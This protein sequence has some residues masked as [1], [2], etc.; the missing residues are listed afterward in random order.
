MALSSLLHPSEAFTE[1]MVVMVVRAAGVLR[2]EC[3]RG[4]M[5]VGEDDES[6]DLREWT[7]GVGW[8]VGVCGYSDVASL[9]VTSRKQRHPGCG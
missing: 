4:V 9:P 6:V 1:P 8:G 5:T 7:D 3:G 2:T